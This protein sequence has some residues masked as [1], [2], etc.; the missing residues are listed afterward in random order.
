MQLDPVLL[1][2]VQFA[3]T[4]GFHYLFPPLT[5]GLGLLMV[6]MEG[7]YLRTGDRH[8]ESLAKF[9]TRIFG[10]I[11]AMGVASGIV[12]E[13]QF[14]TNWATYSRY[15]G[16]IFGAALAA[17]GIFAFFLE[18]GFLAVL[19]FG[20]DRVSP[21]MHFFS[22]VMV[23]LGSIF[24]A[25]WI[26]VANSWQQTP[27]GFELTTQTLP[28][29]STMTVARLT[30]FWQAVFNH[31]TLQRLTHVLIGAMIAGGFLVLSV[32]SYYLLRGRH[33]VFARR[34]IAIALPFS[35]A[36]CLLALLSGHVQGQNVARYQP[37]KLAA[38]EGLYK[39]QTQA[40]LHLFGITDDEKQRVRYGL[41]LPGMLSWLAHGDSRAAVVGL[42][43]FPAAD[44]PPVQLTFQ[45][46]H[47]MV[48]LGMLMI[49]LTTVGTLLLALRR[50]YTQRWLLWVF[51]VAIIMP[52]AA[53]QLGWVAAE[54]GRQ[55]WIVYPTYAGGGDFTPVGGLRTAEAHS[56]AV[57]G[58]QV[59]TSIILISLIYLLLLVTWL[60][61]LDRKIRAGP[62]TPE[63][64]EAAAQRRAGWFAVARERA[65][66]AG[67]SLTDV[68]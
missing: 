42:E 21:R 16:D 26:I 30:D 44:R 6:I 62:E 48:G 65:D 52:M 7:L 25:I 59:L 54:V 19:I 17:E 5:I 55:P 28:D 9:W 15:V 43:A 13:F 35:L 31:S 68:R 41:A 34:G 22:T 20:W 3:L 63:Q 40:P 23:S 12:M 38:M 39:T 2:R 11:F 18:S 56:K 58:Q 1:S 8:Y 67:Q 49:A 66:D 50:L 51:V 14:G 47:A 27:A 4:V 60:Y 29:G 33:E 32:S 64:L 37:A 57:D 53:N 24:S 36:F 45:S 10:L 46:F 61:V